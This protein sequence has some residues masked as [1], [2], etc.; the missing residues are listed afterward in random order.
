MPPTEAD[1]WATRLT[2]LEGEIEAVLDEEKEEK[3][4]NIAE[5]DLKKGENL[6]AHED[7]IKSRPR[8]TWFE[9]EKEK[10]VAKD[11][12]RV[13]LNGETVLGKKTKKKLSGKEKKK[14][15]IK[16]ERRDG[17]TWKKGKKERDEG[18]VGAKGK[19]PSGPVKGK[20]KA[21]KRP[22][23]KGSKVART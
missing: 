11:K 10:K 12:G 14:L 3:I 22:N 4:L 2:E 15:D 1:A 13:E 8:R 16:D 9:N 5:R 17:K 20:G 19:K 23:P 21:T 18:K 7:E 6:V